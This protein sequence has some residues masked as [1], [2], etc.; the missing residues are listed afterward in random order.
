MALVVLGESIPPWSEFPL[1][2]I[3]DGSDAIALIAVATRILIQFNGF[4]N[5]RLREKIIYKLKQI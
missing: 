4:E 2:Y 1:S 5:C 3:N